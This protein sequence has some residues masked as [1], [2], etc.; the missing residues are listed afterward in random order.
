VAA[1][2]GFETTAVGLLDGHGWPVSLPVEVERDGDTLLARLPESD[3]LS[4]EAGSAS[5]LGHTWTRDGPRFLALTGT[6]TI[7]GAVVRFTAHR[8]LRRG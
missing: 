3:G 8:A 1:L 7:D 5:L 2:A 6:A 4:P